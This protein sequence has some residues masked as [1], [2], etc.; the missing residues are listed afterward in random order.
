MTLNFGRISIQ[1]KEAIE[2]QLSQ[3]VQVCLSFYYGHFV[4]GEV[5]RERERLFPWF[6]L[7][8]M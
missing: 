6:E 1:E 7:C 3:C 8:E 2:Q 4:T 5:E